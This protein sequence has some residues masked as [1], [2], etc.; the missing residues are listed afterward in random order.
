MYVVTLAEAKKQLNIESYLTD[1]DAYIS[2]LIEVSYLSIKNACNNTTWI[3]T[4]G[5]TV[6]YESF[7]D[8]T[9]T[10]TTIPLT[11]KHAILILVATLYANRESVSFG[12]PVK[13]PYTLDYLIT[14]YQNLG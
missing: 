1:D 6:D 3:D 2:S 9:V 12:S 4:S 8:I 10:G 13:I 11:I 5:Y 14:P 7:A